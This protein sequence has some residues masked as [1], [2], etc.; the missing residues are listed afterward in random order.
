MLNDPHYRARSYPYQIEARS[1]VI[2]NG[3][4]VVV[5]HNDLL[6]GLEN[7]RPVLAIGSNMSPQQLARKFPAPH[8]GTIPVTRIQLLDF[9]SVYSTHLTSYGAIPATLFPS[10][11][12]RVTLFITWLDKAQEQHMHST[13][14]ASENYHFCRMDG[15]QVQVENGPDLDYLYFYQSSR[16]ALSID[17]YPVPLAEVAALNRRWAAR[18]QNEI[19]EHARQMLAPHMELSAFID[20]NIENTENRR[21]RTDTLHATA[22]PFRFEKLTKVSV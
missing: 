19:L 9:D 21:Q 15:I 2:T 14:I 17:G 12:T 10:P 6:E 16:G 20:D 8:G 11:G 7:R 3:G 5:D 22:M 18:S 1:Y 13:E 4:Y